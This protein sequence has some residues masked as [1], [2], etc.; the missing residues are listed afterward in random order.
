ME[1]FLAQLRQYLESHKE[2]LEATP[3][4]AYAI[5]P[6]PE[7]RSG[8]GVLFLLRQRSISPPNPRQRPVSPI[9][10]F[11]L[12]YIKRDGTI[13]YGCPNA[14]QALETFERAAVGEV[15]PIQHLCDDFDRETKQGQTMTLY[16][17][18]LDAV[19][20]HVRQSLASGAARGLG[21]GGSRDFVLPKKSELPNDPTDFELVTWL[22]LT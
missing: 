3:L 10:P 2:E 14:R 7:Q 22:I 13:R 8:P 1:Y 6:A 12:V 4:G 9:H 18:L 5:A 19:I 16:D 15:R 17:S 21:R 11:F 20:A